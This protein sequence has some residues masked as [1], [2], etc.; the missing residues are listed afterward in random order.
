MMLRKFDSLIMLPHCHFVWWRLFIIQS[1]KSSF[2]LFSY[3]FSN[4]PTQTHAPQ[5]TTK[6]WK[7]L[8]LRLSSWLRSKIKRG[9]LKR[10]TLTLGLKPWRGQNC[11]LWIIESRLISFSLL[12]RACYCVCTDNYYLERSKRIKNAQLEDIRRS[13]GHLLDLNWRFR[14]FFM[15]ISK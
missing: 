8:S 1:S 15:K 7:Y 5:F 2:K 4:Q 10:M 3:F 12:K 9:H 11:H 6:K 14:L 13:W